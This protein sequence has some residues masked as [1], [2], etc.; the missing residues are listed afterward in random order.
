MR[1][2]YRR[3]CHR[4]CHRCC[5]HRCCC[6]RCGACHCCERH[7]GTAAAAAAVD[8]HCFLRSFSYVVVTAPYKTTG[9]LPPPF[10]CFLGS[11]CFNIDG[12]IEYESEVVG[13]KAL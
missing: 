3:C 9:E 12:H 1:H 10:L 2:Y 4:C 8:A 6:Y 13:Y 11:L 5:C 7:R